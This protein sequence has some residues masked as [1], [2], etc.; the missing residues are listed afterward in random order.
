MIPESSFD[1]DSGV[2]I[3]PGL[4]DSDAIFYLYL[5]ICDIFC[6]QEVWSAI[7]DAFCSIVVSATDCKIDYLITGHP[8]GGVA[9]FWCTHLGQ[10][11]KLID[12]ECDGCNTIEFNIG[13]NAVVIINGGEQQRVTCKFFF[14]LITFLL[15]TIYLCTN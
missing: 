4:V 12:I 1:S 3:A 2:G 13:V 8:P 10:N 15:L 6:I 14:F 9:I 11:I 7:Q 5:I